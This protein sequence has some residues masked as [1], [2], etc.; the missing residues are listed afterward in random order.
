M[1]PTEQEAYED[2][3]WFETMT[4]QE[5]KNFQKSFPQSENAVYQ[6]LNSILMLTHNDRFDQAGLNRFDRTLVRTLSAKD[7]YG[8]NWCYSQYS[9]WLLTKMLL[10]YRGQLYKMGVPFP[11]T[12]TNGCV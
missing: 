3:E 11:W 8:L 7:E 4:I 12:L 5:F 9:Q 10:K 6:A 1:F 2:K